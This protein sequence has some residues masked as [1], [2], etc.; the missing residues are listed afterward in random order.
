MD[1]S[2]TEEQTLLRDSVERFLREH[3]DFETRRALAQSSDGYARDNWRVFAE[4]GWLALPFSEDAGGL[5]GSQIDVMILMEAL[6]RGLVLEPYLGSVLLAGRLLEKM[7][8]AAQKDAWLAPIIVG[9][10]RLAFAWAEPDARYDLAATG[11]RAEIYVDGGYHLSGRKSVVI[12]APGADGLIVLARTH[13]A[14]GDRNGLSCFIVPADASGL[15]IQSYRTIDG[16][17]AADVT[18]EKVH[19]GKDAVLGPPDEV[20]E[21]VEGVLDAATAAL[22]GEALGLM[23]ASLDST[24]DY[25]LQR[26]QFG[27]PLAGFQVLQHRLADMT[28][29]LEEARSLTCVANIRIDEGDST[30]TRRAVS[31]AKAELERHA[32]F[33]AAQAVQLHGGMGV[34][35]EMAVG[36]CFK[37]LHAILRLFGDRTWH[38]RRFA[39]LGTETMGHSARA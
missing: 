28:V 31:T 11:V 26:Q 9:E 15:T 33:I 38:L 27:R 34:S 10:R 2:L 6:G 18:F 7:G 22:C 20:L 16:G 13:G 29:A 23:Q 1:F 8:S 36:T 37:R 30:A 25:L 24:R 35:E 12:G 5:G 14:R 4:M 21:T 19:I 17:R 32:S 3:Y 39:A